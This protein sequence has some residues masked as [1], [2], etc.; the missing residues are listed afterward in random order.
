MTLLLPFP[1]LCRLNY[2]A[3]VL[4][5]V[6]GRGAV[7]PKGIEYYNNLINELV[8]HGKNPSEFQFPPPYHVENDN[9]NIL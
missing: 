3:I 6:G 2:N 9:C 4:L 1:L 7:N 5:C 8:S